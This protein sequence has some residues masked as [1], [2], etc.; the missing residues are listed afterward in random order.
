ML[1]SRQHRKTMITL[2]STFIQH[3]ETLGE[4]QNSL[5]LI[6]TGDC[7]LH[8]HGPLRECAVVTNEINLPKRPVV[9]A[10]L[11]AVLVMSDQVGDITLGVHFAGSNITHVRESYFDDGNMAN[12]EHLPLEKPYRP[13]YVYWDVTSSAQKLQNMFFGEVYPLTF[14]VKYTHIKEDSRDS[15]NGLNNGLNT[16]TN[17][18]WPGSHMALQLYTGP[19]LEVNKIFGGRKRSRRSA[20]QNDMDDKMP[21]GC[22]GFNHPYSTLFK[23]CLFKYILNADQIKSTTFT[24]PFFLP[25]MLPLNMCHGRCDR[26][27]ESYKNRQQREK[28]IDIPVD[29]QHTTLLSQYYRGLPKQDQDVVRSF[30]P[31]CGADK[32]NDLV[33]Y[34][35]DADKNINKEILPRA[36]KTSCVCK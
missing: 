23:C 12:E 2:V 19:S 21:D 10:R 16:R 1:L 17:I 35:L 28:V 29:N 32:A 9:Y 6:K 25:P 15:A 34:Y 14:T 36:V 33:I 4:L 20:L 3:K 24:R 27:L 5:T 31:C 18:L 11:S 7:R 8:E 22:P 26:S 13:R 30:M